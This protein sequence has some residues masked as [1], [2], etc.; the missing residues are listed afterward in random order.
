MK[1]LIAEFVEIGA[2][3]TAQWM[4]TQ[5]PLQSSTS[6]CHLSFDFHRYKTA[7]TLP[8]HATHK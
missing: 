3:E 7:P 5:E 1:T 8:P 6:Q 2:G 4:S